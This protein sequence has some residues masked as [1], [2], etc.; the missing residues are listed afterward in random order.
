MS[1]LRHQSKIE[2]AVVTHRLTM[3]RVAPTSL[4]ILTVML[5]HGKMMARKG[6]I[7]SFLTAF[8]VSFSL[9]KLTRIHHN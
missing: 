4:F 1:D 5:K 6:A 9:V 2:D 7:K 3:A 8:Q